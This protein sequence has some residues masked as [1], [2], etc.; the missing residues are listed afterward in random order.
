MASGAVISKDQEMHEKV[1]WAEPSAS[2][3]WPWACARC[4]W[5]KQK[6]GRRDLGPGLEV[7]RFQRDLSGLEAAFV[8]AQGFRAFS[9]LEPQRISSSRVVEARMS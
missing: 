4:P 2:E 9:D 3:R 1:K 6:K 5:A 8:V 7:A